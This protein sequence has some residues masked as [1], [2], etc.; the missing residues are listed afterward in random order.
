MFLSLWLI[1]P[2]AIVLVVV[3][4]FTALVMFLREYAFRPKAYSPEEFAML[5][6][7]LKERQRFAVV[8]GPFEPNKQEGRSRMRRRRELT[9]SLG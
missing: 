7:K 3:V 1:I 8:D 9:T 2:V 4:L 5:L 6:G